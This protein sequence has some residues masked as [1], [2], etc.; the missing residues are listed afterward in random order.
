MPPI[1]GLRPQRR[2]SDRQRESN[3]NQLLIGRPKLICKN[4]KTRSSS[5]NYWYRSQ[6]DWVG[7]KFIF[8][9]IIVL[10]AFMRYP[11][12]NPIW[13][14]AEAS[15]Q[16][17]RRACQQWW[18][19]CLVSSLHCSQSVP[20]GPWDVWGSVNLDVSATPWSLKIMF[21]EIMLK[22]FSR[23]FPSSKIKFYRG[24]KSA[25]QQPRFSFG[26]GEWRDGPVTW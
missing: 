11:P 9:E 14:E 23:F 24:V 15:D 22:L 25:I 26:S 3:W 7:R 8:L 6:H 16:Q 10:P 4:L 1:P 20:A 21:W 12:G 18:R 2:K 19:W 5:S 17:R 13:S